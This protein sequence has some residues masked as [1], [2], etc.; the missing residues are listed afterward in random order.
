M[1][2]RLSDTSA[3]IAATR[4]LDTVVTAM[5]G[6]AAARTREAQSRLAGVRAYA[7][8]LGEAI[9]AALALAPQASAEPRRS[10]RRVALVFCAE[11]GFVGAF[12]ERMLAAARRRKEA[13]LWVVGERGVSLAAEQ[14]L[15]VD[16]SAPMAAHVEDAPMLADQIADALYQRIGAK[17]TASVTL[18]HGLPETAGGA[19]LVERPLVPLDLARFPLPRGEIPPLATLPPQE[20]LANLA[21]EYLFAELCEAVVLS[22]AAENEARMLAMIAARNNVRKTLEELQAR[23]RR[24]RQEQITEEI[25]EL[26]R[27]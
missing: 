12:N 21:Q 9:G 11:Q 16:W 26:V 14:G 1:S 2:E 17:Q 6:V 7:S 25:I 18:I 3:R 13:S 10:A 4:Q 27:G 5:R 19:R 20:L 22:F 15:K 23:Y 8:A 24:L